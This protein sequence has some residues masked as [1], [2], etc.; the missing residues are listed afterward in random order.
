MEIDNRKMLTA[1]VAIMLLL[2]PVVT[3]AA[4]SLRIASCLLFALFFP[5]YTL[6]S[7]L[8]PKRDKLSG[9][10]QLALSLGI[11]IALVPLIGLALNYTPWGIK[12]HP[13]LV[14]V[15][16]FIVVTAAT[17]WYRQRQLMVADRFSVTFQVGLPWR[18]GMTKP[19]LSFSIG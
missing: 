16:L 3:F 6:L 13:I 2:F 19:V 17:G 4:G 8:F 14:S 7:A 10:K 5:G 9:I 12:L 11:S 1:I 18:A 15:T